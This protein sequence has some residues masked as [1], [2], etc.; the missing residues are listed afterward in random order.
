MFVVSVGGRGREGAAGWFVTGE[1]SYSGARQKQQLREALKKVCASAHAL[2]VRLTHM[3]WSSI[4]SPNSCVVLFVCLFLFSAYMSVINMTH[5]KE[6]VVKQG[7]LVNMLMRHGTVREDKNKI[8][9]LVLLFLSFIKLFIS[10]W[11][12][13][14]KTT[15]TGRKKSLLYTKHK[16]CLN[17]F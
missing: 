1:N 17:R 8:S 7:Q 12:I 15:D 5:H 6:I 13:L 16:I 3:Q 14:K 2:G 11:V 9:S 10:T 4:M